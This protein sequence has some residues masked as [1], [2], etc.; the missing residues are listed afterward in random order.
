MTLSPSRNTKGSSQ[1][2]R[3]PKTYSEA[4]RGM[5]YY[6]VNLANFRDNE[7]KHETIEQYKIYIKVRSDG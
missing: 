1:N 5:P 4:L 3:R 7:L 6:S 2:G